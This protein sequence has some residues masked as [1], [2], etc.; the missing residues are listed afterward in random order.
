MKSDNYSV[1]SIRVTTSWF[2]TKRFYIPMLFDG[3]NKSRAFQNEEE[4]PTVWGYETEDEAWTA[5][6]A[7]MREQESY[8]ENYAPSKGYREDFHADG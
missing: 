2:G 4:Y 6:D 3:I 5:C 8:Q 7:H 1:K